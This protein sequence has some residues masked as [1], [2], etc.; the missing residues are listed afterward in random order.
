MSLKNAFFYNKK[1][2][3]IV[4]KN[5]KKNFSLKNFGAISYEVPSS[6]NHQISNREAS[7][8]RLGRGTSTW[9]EL[10]IK[11]LPSNT[12]PNQLMNYKH[13]NSRKFVS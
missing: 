2:L 13:A 10:Q 7:Y 3:I 11:S 12:R 8:R 6:K 9:G 1:S 4:K 5:P